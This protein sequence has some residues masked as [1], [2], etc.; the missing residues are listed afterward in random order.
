MARGMK[1]LLAL[2]AL[3]T[4][5]LHDRQGAYAVEYALLAPMFLLL[6][7]AILE[8][9]IVLLY[10]INLSS[11]TEDAAEY[12]RTS[13]INRTEVT[14]TELRDIISSNLLFGFKEERLHVNLVDV[15]DNDYARI[16]PSFPISD[17]FDKPDRSTKQMILS[18]GYDW[19]SFMPAS[20]YVVSYKGDR[21]QLQEFAMVVT[22]IRVTE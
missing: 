3:A 18:V 9:G 17:G 11:A 5:L 6:V 14:E 16:T 19:E 15:P 7:L 1:R 21:T 13:A 2:R 22:A 8:I 12:I 20:S 4:R 10:M